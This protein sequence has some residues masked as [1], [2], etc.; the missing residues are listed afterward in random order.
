M[1]MVFYLWLFFEVGQEHMFMS[2]TEMMLN[3]KALI[4]SQE[5][6][7]F[8]IK[9]LTMSTVH[10]PCAFIIATLLRLE[11]SAFMLQVKD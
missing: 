2:H 6:D 11:I 9:T 3:F 4:N 8:R 1:Q 5:P 7:I 10:S